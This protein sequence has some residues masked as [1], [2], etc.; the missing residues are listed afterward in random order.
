[1]LHLHRLRCHRCGALRQESRD[2]APARKRY[3]SALARLVLELCEQM[4]I[5]AV[6]RYVGLDW[7]CPGTSTRS[8]PGRWRV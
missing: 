4:T 6:A 1:V 3:T 5:L 8:P 2:V 7:E